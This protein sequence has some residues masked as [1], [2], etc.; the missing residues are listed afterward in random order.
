[1][2]RFRA[3]I[4]ILV[5]AL[6]TTPA[7]AQRA[8]ILELPNG[9]RLGIAY[10]PAGPVVLTE[11][12]VVKV[13]PPVPATNGR[14]WAVVIRSVDTLAADQAEALSN[15]RQWTDEQ[16]ADKVAHWEFAPDAVDHLGQSDKRVAGYVSLIPAGAKLPYVFLAQAQSD[17]KTAIL[18]QGELPADAAV[19]IAKM[20]EHVR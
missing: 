11:I 15:F 13:A 8:V 6:F 12:T 5:L 19:I 7:F 14:V 18:W 16:S 10:T 4:A 1:M 9:Q 2:V 17:G 3:R 20:K